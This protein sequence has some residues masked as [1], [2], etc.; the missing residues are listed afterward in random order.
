[1][2]A[3]GVLYESRSLKGDTTNEQ[4]KGGNMNYLAMAFPIRPRDVTKPLRWTTSLGLMPLTNVAYKLQYHQDIGNTDGEQ[5]IITQEG[6]GGLTQF[7][8]ANGYRIKKGLS[9]GLCAAYVFGPISNK[10]SNTLAETNQ[11]YPYLIRVEE[12][13]TT[14]DFAFEAGFAYSVDSLFKSKRYRI[15]I[16]GTYG[17]GTDLK[18]DQTVIFSRL[19]LNNPDTSIDSLTLSRDNG[20]ITIPERIGL[21]LSLA[22][23]QKWSAGIDFTYQDWAK[24]SGVD[25]EDAVG[26]TQSWKV[27]IGGEYTPDLF[28]V[29]NILQRITYRIGSSIERSPFLANGKQVKDFGI[30]FGLSVP[31]GRSS[32]DFAFRM[33]KR[34]NKAENILEESYFKVYFGLTLNDQWFI[35]RK[36]D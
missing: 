8:W 15:A 3:A 9:V 23:G 33:G 6:K 10:Y 7:Y 21:G 16:G 34:G 12:E 13:V 1:V 28:S 25:Q 32:L 35:K 24:F 4:S 31:A 5:A 30:N 19:D 11:T 26:G 22:N 2:F 29:D 17:F 18:A 20:L 27:A 36:F 14:H